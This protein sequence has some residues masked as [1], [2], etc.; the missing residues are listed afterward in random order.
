MKEIFLI[1]VWK[2]IKDLFIKMVSL[3]FLTWLIIAFV[4]WKNGQQ[5]DINF[6]IF[7]ACI[8][9]GKNYLDIQKNKEIT[10]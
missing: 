8:A 5:I 10:K 2:R 7:T 9:L 1:T 4:Y 3:T 6:L